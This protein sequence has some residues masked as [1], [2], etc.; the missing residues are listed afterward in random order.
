MTSPVEMA[1]GRMAMQKLLALVFCVATGAIDAAEAEVP[2]FSVVS[3]WRI[4]VEYGEQREEFSL[5]P[6]TVRQVVDEPMTLP[7]FAHDQ[8]LLAK[9]KSPLRVISDGTC[10]TKHALDVR[11]VRV[12][13]R[14]GTPLERGVDWDME[15]EW[16]RF[17]YLK[18]GRVAPG[19][20]DVLISYDYRMM[21]VDAIVCR[22]DGSIELRKGVDHIASPERPFVSVGEKLLGTVIVEPSMRGLDDEHLFPK[23]EDAPAFAA[24]GEFAHFCPRT[25]EKLKKGIPVRIMAWGD[26]VTGLKYLGRGGRRW[27]NKFV[28]RLEKIYPQARI[29]LITVAWGGH[30]SVDFLN[31]P[32]TDRE[33]HFATAIL[34]ARPDLVVSE[35]VND[36]F[37]AGRKMDAIYGGILRDFRSIGAEW[38]ICTPHYVRPDHMGAKSM[39]TDSDPRWNTMSI[40][41]FCRTN[42]L[43]CADAALR[44]GHL[45]REGEPY[46]PL[47]V[48]NLNHPDERGV[49]FYADA[50]ISLLPEEDFTAKKIFEATFDGTAVAVSAGG[51]ACQPLVA[52]DLEWTHGR[53]GK[54]LR[55]R[56]GTSA[57]LAYSAEGNAFPKQG[58]VSFWFKP[59]A[60]NFTGSY[61]VGRMFFSTHRPEKRLGSGTLW[62]WKYGQLLRADQSDDGDSYVTAPAQLVSNAWNHLVYTWDVDST[63]IFLNGE[64]VTP[65]RLSCDQIR[66]A[67][68]SA[69]SEDG[70][71][72]SSRRAFQSFYV[73]CSSDGRRMDGAMDDF[74]IWSRPLTSDEVQKLCPPTER[75]KGLPPFSRQ[76][77]LKS[78]VEKPYGNGGDPGPLELVDRIILDGR[79][80]PNERFASVGEWH[81]GEV[82]GRKYL[83]SSGR[84]H[85]RIAVRF[86]ID[87]SH[88]LYFFEIDY[89]DDKKRTMDFVVQGSRETRW[90]GDSEAD[91]VLQSGVACGDEYANSGR[92]LTHRC[93]YWQRGGDVTLSVMTLRGGAP[94]AIGEVRVFRVKSG[95][96][97]CAAVAEPPANDDGW[98][99]T[100]ALYYEDPAAGYDFGVDGT[101][102]ERLR[103]QIA[104]LA[105]SMKY[106]GQNVLCYPGAWYD[107]LI[108]GEKYNPRWH[109]HGYREEYY[110]AFD[111]EGLGFMPTLNW[112]DMM[113]PPGTLTSAKLQDGTFLGTPFSAFDKGGVNRLCTHGQPPDANI[114]HP[115][116]QEVIESAVDSLVEEGR[117]HSS[118]RG[119]VL[120]LSRHSLLWFGDICA[121][122]NDYCI[123]RFAVERHIDVPAFH[124]AERGREYARWIK[125]NC[126]SEWVDWR[127][128]VVADFYLRLAKKLSDARPDLKLVVNSFLLPQC[129]AE[130]FGSEG[131]IPEQNRL[132]GLDVRKLADVPNVSICQTQIPADYRWFAPYDPTDPKDNGRWRSH[133][134]RVEP[135]HRL[136]YQKRGDFGQLSNSVFPWVNQHDRYWESAIGKTS[137]GVAKESLSCEWLFEC[138]WRCSTVNPAGRHA[139]R[140]YAVPLRYHDLLAISKGGFLVGT[141]GTEDVLVSWI[142][143]FRSLPAVHMKE[144]FREGDVVGR[145][146]N[147]KDKTYCYVVNT[148]CLER[149]VDVAIPGGS[150]DLVDGRCVNSGKTARRCRIKLLPYELRSYAGIKE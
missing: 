67:L 127:C 23:T 131:F 108:D 94:A 65:G 27:Q 104:R 22:K 25:Y 145:T 114:A 34:G 39:K 139:L 138:P 7:P 150:V 63:H 77:P 52:K 57:E 60:A 40:R 99:R 61:D 66:S 112:I 29:E 115:M 146:C 143:A 78:Y 101:D 106:V 38:I 32:A 16:A 20:A 80:I 105:A 37:V 149:I 79:E 136:L 8:W 124:G 130:S 140:A 148:G 19:K 147:F 128:D 11:S 42:G 50:L 35:F 118:F 83:E 97:P 64:D 59:D 90:D 69:A 100:F 119:I 109:T 1:K 88:P 70:L 15:P 76:F 58:S 26:S 49:S 85:D 73:G 10:S 51:A 36:G 56:N 87:T 135:L 144:F 44:W 92:M 31:A 125:D 107:G 47:L 72:F 75:P 30:S 122:Y 53:R 82:D 24:T 123:R 9:G 98:R 134:A 116:V 89:P 91:Y 28:K 3:D 12:R 93:H 71:S 120:H 18:G 43:A 111:R 102:L 86:S 110:D 33:H 95:R 54:A 45:W 48:N 113:L 121:G 55:M 62:F 126:L 81:V 41:E 5:S 142:R 21:R 96:L 46:L 103:E 2:R 117:N 129:S 14:D 141:Y 6:P 13:L 74:A 4:S 17:G 84:A 133:R 137:A 68:K 132:A